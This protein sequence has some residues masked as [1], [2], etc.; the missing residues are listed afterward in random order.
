MARRSQTLEILLPTPSEKGKDKSNEISLI[1]ALNPGIVDQQISEFSTSNDNNSIDRSLN[2]KSTFKSNLD[3]ELA[4][5]TFHPN[6]GPSRTRARSTNTIFERDH[7]NYFNEKSKRLA[8]RKGRIKTR[9][10]ILDFSPSFV[11]EPKK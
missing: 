4:H 1:S 7:N 2:R 10:K 11:P 5:C 8:Q 6:I 3:L 9:S